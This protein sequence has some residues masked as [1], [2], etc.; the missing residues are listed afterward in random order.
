M[1]TT[2]CL[3][4]CSY[5]HYVGIP[6]LDS[7]DDCSSPRAE[8]RNIANDHYSIFFLISIVVDFAL[9]RSHYQTNRDGNKGYGYGE[10]S[11]FPDRMSQHGPWEM[12]SDNLPTH[13][14]PDDITDSQSDSISSPTRM[15]S[16]ELLD[17]YET[18]SRV[19]DPPY[20]V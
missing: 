17:G 18:R 9:A 19:L 6:L 2:N 15:N 3:S 8:V 5:H 13:T 12:V 10:R 7:S 4:R 16:D 20:P 14:E 1:P 11:A